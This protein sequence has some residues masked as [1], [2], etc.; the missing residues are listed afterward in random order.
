MSY[1]KT[2]YLQEEHINLKNTILCRNTSEGVFD[3]F[4]QTVTSGLPVHRSFPE[5]SHSFHQIQHLLKLFS[6]VPVPEYS[7]FLK[8]LDYKS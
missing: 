5:T 3:H 6:N 4:A 1:T 7:C 2:T 8:P